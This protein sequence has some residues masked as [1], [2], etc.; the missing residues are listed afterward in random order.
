MR[1]IAAAPI[2]PDEME[3]SRDCFSEPRSS[4]A[5]IS[6]IRRSSDR[7]FAIHAGLLLQPAGLNQAAAASG[8]SPIPSD[9]V[10]L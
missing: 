5:A 8:K 9:R 1:G 4:T 7:D 6:L 10:V 2:Q 3:R